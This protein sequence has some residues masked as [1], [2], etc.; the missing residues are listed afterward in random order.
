MFHLLKGV[1]KDIKESEM[2]Q[3]KVFVIF[4]FFICCTIRNICNF[5][6]HLPQVATAFAV[7]S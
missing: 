5:Y 2:K 4:Q 1:I 7:A 3:E 6:S